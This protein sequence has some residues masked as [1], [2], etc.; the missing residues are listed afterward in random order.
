MTFTALV[1]MIN[2]FKGIYIDRS[3]KTYCLKV[4]EIYMLNM[5]KYYKPLTIATLV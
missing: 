2:K 4:R 3:A 1:V 5:C